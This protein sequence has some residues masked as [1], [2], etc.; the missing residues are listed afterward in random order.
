MDTYQGFGNHSI[1]GNNSSS[2]W[3]GNYSKIIY[4]EHGECVL[5]V[6]W[7]CNGEFK[8]VV[9]SKVPKI[10]F[11]TRQVDNFS[12]CQRMSFADIED[13]MRDISLF[14]PSILVII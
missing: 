11:L 13:E 1:D 6:L 2:S 3:N 5:R 10:G 12:Q 4:T 14:M 9:I 7:D 8:A